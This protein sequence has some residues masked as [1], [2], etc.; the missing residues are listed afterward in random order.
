MRDD[1]R[2]VRGPRGG[3]GRG[4]GRPALPAPAA[5]AVKG[6]QERGDVWQQGR[7]RRSMSTKP[8]GSCG[9]C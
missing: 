2:L 1:E 4:G 9:G 8:G 3:W 5:L 6:L 7:G